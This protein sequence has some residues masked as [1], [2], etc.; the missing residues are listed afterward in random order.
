VKLAGSGPNNTYIRIA[1]LASTWAIV[2]I[3][4]AWRK[5]QVNCSKVCLQDVHKQT[6]HMY[7]LAVWNQEK[8]LRQMM[9]A[10]IAGRIRSKKKKYAWPLRAR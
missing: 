10:A 5:A 1:K 7:V 2:L 9:V 4:S 3:H 8:P 6:V